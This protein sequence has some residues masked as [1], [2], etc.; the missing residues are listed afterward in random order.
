[1]RV[2]SSSSMR[3]LVII[4]ALAVEA[5]GGSSSRDAG[6]GG[7]SASE[8]GGGTAGTPGA[9]GGTAG[10]APDC[11]EYEAEKRPFTLRFVNQRSQPLFV[12]D[13]APC[14]P[15]VPFSVSND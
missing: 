5:C 6:A 15:F 7:T 14:N 4:I 10:A 8:A 12:R 1:M 2:A 13:Q 11:S 9:G 3:A